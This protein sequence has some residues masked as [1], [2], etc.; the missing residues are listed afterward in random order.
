MTVAELRA[1]LAGL[2]GDMLVGVPDQDDT[3]CEVQFAGV[4]SNPDGFY[5][6]LRANGGYP[7]GLETQKE[8][9]R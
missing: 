6:L 1:A 3:V 5:F 2:D 4:T 7:L 8:R 9:P